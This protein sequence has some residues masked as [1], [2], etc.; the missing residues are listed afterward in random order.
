MLVDNLLANL[1]LEL[2]IPKKLD[3]ELDPLLICPPLFD[4]THIYCPYR[5]AGYPQAFFDEF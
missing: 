4:K 2:Q 5:S 1:V 3:K